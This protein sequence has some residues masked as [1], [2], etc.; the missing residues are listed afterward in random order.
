MLKAKLKKAIEQFYEK[1][2]LLA[3]LPSGYGKSLI[4]QLLVLLA[5]RAGIHTSYV[6][7]CW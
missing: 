1:K 3:I 7:V 4:Y 5:K 2:D 6:A